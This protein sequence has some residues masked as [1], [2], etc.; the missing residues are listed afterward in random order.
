LANNEQRNC[1]VV[2]VKQLDVIQ[3]LLMKHSYPLSRKLPI[4]LIFTVFVL[5]VSNQSHSMWALVS[6]KGVCCLL[7]FS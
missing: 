6:G 1:M 2:R 3:K 4:K 5:K 7:S